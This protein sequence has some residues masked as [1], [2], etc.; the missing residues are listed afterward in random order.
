MTERER[1]Q[2]A[3]DP[4]A[5]SSERLDTLIRALSAE[6]RRMVYVYLTEHESAPVEELVDVVVGWSRARDR[7]AAACNWTQTHI[8]LHHQHL[9]ALAEAGVINY[10]SDQGTASIASLSPPATEIL[11][12]IAD[13]DD[14]RTASG[15]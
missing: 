6:P 15:A 11:S 12:T 3:R 9:P 13:L 2:Q 1:S 8:A 14:A 10:D 4:V 7:S 5:L